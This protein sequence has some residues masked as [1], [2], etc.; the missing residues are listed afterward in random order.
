[1]RK[2][3]EE[4]VV[5]LEFEVLFEVFCC[6]DYVVVVA[7][8]QE[9]GSL[10]QV[11]RFVEVDDVFYPIN[12]LGKELNCR[13][14]GLDVLLVVRDLQWKDETGFLVADF[15]LDD[16]V[17]VGVE[18]LC[19]LVSDYVSQ[20]IPLR[21]LLGDFKLVQQ[22]VRHLDDSAL[23]NEDVIRVFYM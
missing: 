23:L 16:L 22:L 4:E 7:R 10:L 2:T 14:E 9:V 11:L 1:V 8:V 19:H 3:C 21:L 13:S 20:F 12:Q 18:V 5:A 17:E 6:P 15:L